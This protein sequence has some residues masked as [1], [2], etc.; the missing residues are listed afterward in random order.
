MTAIHRDVLEYKAI[1]I[2]EGTPKDQYFHY[3]DSLRDGM[4]RR[5]FLVWRRDTCKYWLY[6]GSDDKTGQELFCQRVPPES[7]HCF[8]EVIFDKFPQR[9]YVDI[10]LYIQDTDC[11]KQKAA[12]DLDTVLTT[13]IDLFSDYG[14]D[15][16]MSQV[17]VCDSSG[18]THNNKYKVSY[19]IIFDIVLT[20]NDAKYIFTLAKQKLNIDG[21]ELIDSGM[22]KSIQNL[23]TV[24]STHPVDN[25]KLMPPHGAARLNCFVNVNYL[26]KPVRLMDQNGKKLRVKRPTNKT[27]ANNIKYI[28]DLAIDYTKGWISRPNSTS[29]FITYKRTPAADNNCAICKR[30]H[31]NENFPYIQIAGTEV[32]FRCHRNK[33]EYIVI[34]QVKGNRLKDAI[35]EPYIPDIPLFNEIYNNPTMFPYPNMPTLG[36]RANMKVGKTLEAI[37]CAENHQRVLVIAYRKTFTRE[38]TKQMKGFVSYLDLPKDRPIDLRRTPKVIIQLESLPRLSREALPDLVILDEVE[39]IIEQFSSSTMKSFH[40]CAELFKFFVKRSKNVLAMDANLGERAMKCINRIRPN[41]YY[42]YN[43][44]ANNTDDKI[45]ITDKKSQ[46]TTKIEELVKA[47]KNIVIPTNCKKY[48]D[49]ISITLNKLVNDIR[50]LMITSDMTDAE[51]AVVFA[52]VNTE[53]SKYQVV[54]FTPTCSAGV[55]FTNKHFDYVCGYFINSTNTVE[56]QRQSM[57]RA[58]DISSGEYYICLDTVKKYHHYHTVDEIAEAIKYQEFVGKSDVIDNTLTLKYKD[59]VIRI[60]NTLANLIVL[61]NTFI[62]N[63]SR[64]QQIEL[65]VKQCRSTGATVDI[66]STEYNE[67]VT[68]RF[69]EAEKMVSDIECI[70]IANSPDIDYLTYNNLLESSNLTKEQTNCIRKFILRRKYNLEQNIIMPEFVKLYYPKACQFIYS[71]LQ[72]ILGYKDTRSSLYDIKSNYNNYYDK[73]KLAIDLLKMCGYNHVTDTTEINKSDLYKKWIDNKPLLSSMMKD[74]CH[75]FDDKQTIKNWN[76]FRSVLDFFNGIFMVMYGLKLVMRDQNKEGRNKII[77]R[78]YYWNGKIFGKELSQTTPFIIPYHKEH[79]DDPD[80]PIL[81]I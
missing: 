23:R 53:W 9:P 46:L 43:R 47:G 33:T 6:L 3:I 16:D 2:P 37:K 42:I 31:L 55:S 11:A 76:M 71:R 8:D 5:D 68:S 25:R 49:A 12:D 72:E 18:L 44:F 69:K 59:N 51:K 34:G 54:I 1:R 81:D 35:D 52:D 77:I 80:D 32:R 64:C 63:L 39:S 4:D 7:I 28:T 41:A 78:H 58:R 30:V 60:D 14:I 70:N 21:K 40:Q 67:E 29:T 27:V 17:I 15:L 65:F 38:K 79:I 74:I 26:D 10:D 50:I 75:V 36:I 56:S 61:Q 22:Y 73:H 13:Y 20:Y 19:H 24:Y 62:S 45:H 66:F 48:A 57:Y